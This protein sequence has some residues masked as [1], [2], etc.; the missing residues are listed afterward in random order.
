MASKPRVPAHRTGYPEAE[1]GE[2]GRKRYGPRSVSKLLGQDAFVEAVVGV[3]HHVE[4][5]A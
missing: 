3:E 1:N 5:D 2:Q 4:I